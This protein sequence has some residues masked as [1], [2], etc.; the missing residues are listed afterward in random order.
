MHAIDLNF[1][2]LLDELYSLYLD[3]LETSLVL[4]WR[5]L[6]YYL[7]QYA[8]M[9]DSGSPQAS[10]GQ[11]RFGQ[12]MGSSFRATTGNASIGLGASVGQNQGSKN[13]RPTLTEAQSLKRDAGHVVRPV[14]D[15]LANLHLVSAFFFF[16][17]CSLG[18]SVFSFLPF[19]L[20]LTRA[21]FL[22]SVVC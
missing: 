1:F 5:H 10:L 14:L 11:S 15:N 20:D 19:N 17:L 16:C 8:G 4:L 21:F 6:E 3:L 12:S 9:L 18:L 7:G 13:Y 2:F 22:L